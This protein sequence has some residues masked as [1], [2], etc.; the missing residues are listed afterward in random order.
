MVAH[1]LMS[2]EEKRW[3]AV[4]EDETVGFRAN[5]PHPE[6]ARDPGLSLSSFALASGYSR[7]GPRCQHSLTGDDLEAPLWPLAAAAVQPPHADP[8]AL[9]QNTRP[10][11]QSAL[12]IMH[13]F[14]LLCQS[15]YFRVQCC[16][17]LMMKKNTRVLL[18]LLLLEL[19]TFA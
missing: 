13:S 8:R 7:S 15:S 16:I 1:I 5:R 4:L 3:H 9:F 2:A 19:R 17:E 14:V 11:M 18:F 10:N 6:Q 12:K